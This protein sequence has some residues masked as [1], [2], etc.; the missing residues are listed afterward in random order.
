[1]ID[2]GYLEYTNKNPACQVL[3]AENVSLTFPLKNRIP[4][5]QSELE[6]CFGR[7]SENLGQLRCHFLGYR[8]AVMF[9][10]R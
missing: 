9:H 3:F 10:R 7:N 2:F 5:I 4:S 1:M 8:A 6:I